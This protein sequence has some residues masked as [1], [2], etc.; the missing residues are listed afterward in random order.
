MVVADEPDTSIGSARSCFYMSI[1]ILAGK[2]FHELGKNF[3]HFWRLMTRAKLSYIR[4][5]IVMVYHIRVTI[6]FKMVDVEEETDSGT[7]ESQD[8]WSVSSTEH[9]NTYHTNQRVSSLRG[10]ILS[11]VSRASSGSKTTKSVLVLGKSLRHSHLKQCIANTLF[12][13][14]RR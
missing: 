1:I 12:L 9:T 3:V 6:T 5:M 2:W 8:L 11:E 4:H 10:S 13:G 14:R 7:T